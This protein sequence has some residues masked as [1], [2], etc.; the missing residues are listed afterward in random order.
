V[1]LSKLR[2]LKVPIKITGS[3]DR[4]NILQNSSNF[5]VEI[6]EKDYL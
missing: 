6:L 1:S 3:I 2:K 4:K 5:N